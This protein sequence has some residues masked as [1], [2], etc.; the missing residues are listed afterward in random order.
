MIQNLARGVQAFTSN[1]FLVTGD[2][3]AL[4]DAGAN[5]DL[6]D[7]VTE[8]VDDVDRLYLTHTHPDHV[9]N[10]EAARAAFD[11]ETWGYDTESA[12]VDN[13]VADGDTVPIGDGATSSAPPIVAQMTDLLAPARAADILEIGTGCGY[14]AAVTA[15]LLDAGGMV[16]SVEVDPTLAETAM[17]NLRAAGAADRVR[18][19]VADGSDGWPAGAPY[20]GAYLTCAA[21]QV[22]PA[23]L[24]QC[25]VGAR[26]VAPLGTDTQRLVSMTVGADGV[27]ERRDHGAVRF[28]RMR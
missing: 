18:I 13:A 2:T 9:E 15:A 1:V 20:D 6:V 26:V 8:H 21:P 11:V 23:V 25:R 12:Y 7:R 19:R 16:H 10:V 4:V 28:V 5:F 24:A 17:A 22:P 3:T 27:R 14:P